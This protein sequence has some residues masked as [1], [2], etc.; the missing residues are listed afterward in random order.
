MFQKPFSKKKGAV[1]QVLFHPTKPW[2]F[3]AT[4]QHVRIYD[5]QKCELKRKLF[6]G[7]K[8]VSCMDLHPHGNNLFIGG[9]DRVFTW[10]DMELAAKP[11]KTMKNHSGA[12]RSLC[13]HQRYPLLATVSDDATAI[14][15]HA[16]VFLPIYIWNL[17]E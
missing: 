16:K 11:W 9:L 17:D 4:Q 12:I 2:F 13:Y 5:L 14:V 15:Y 1:Q 3:V 6:T 7:S 10:L 8:F